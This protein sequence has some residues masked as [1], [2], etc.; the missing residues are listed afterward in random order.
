MVQDDFSHHDMMVMFIVILT[1]SR[2]DLETRLQ[3]HRKRVFMFDE[4]NVRVVLHF[5]A[6]RIF[7]VLGVH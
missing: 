6:A 3:A 5:I 4:S 1:R 7:I 2:V